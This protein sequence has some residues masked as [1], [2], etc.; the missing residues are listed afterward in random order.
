MASGGAA[1][2]EQRGRGAEQGCQR[3]KKER[4]GPRDWF[5]KIEKSRDL[6]VN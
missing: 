2:E 4:R 6:T 1:A 3:K 5:A